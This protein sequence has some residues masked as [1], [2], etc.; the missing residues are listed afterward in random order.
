MGDLKLK[1]E[2]ATGTSITKHQ[3]SLMGVAESLDPVMDEAEMDLPRT[4]TEDGLPN[5]EFAVT[6][7]TLELARQSSKLHPPEDSL[8]LESHI[9]EVSCSEKESATD[10][11]HRAS[12]SPTHQPAASS[13]THLIASSPTYLG[14]P[15]EQTDGGGGRA[16]P[17]KSF[18]FLRRSHGDRVG[19]SLQASSAEKI[20]KRPRLLS[21]LMGNQYN[22]DISQGTWD[23]VD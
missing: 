9:S 19:G 2:G 15:T 23:S 11:A 5:P 1:Y 7:E 12:S 8:G 10:H 21:V 16:S 18:S 22:T 17:K 6:P 3:H 4:T 20:T 14:S 13:P